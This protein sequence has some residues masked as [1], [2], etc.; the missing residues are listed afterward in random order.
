M[1][2]TT[3][4]GLLL[5]IDKMKYDLEHMGSY[6]GKLKIDRAKMRHALQY[7]TGNLDY[8]RVHCGVIAIDYVKSIKGQIKR[9]Q[10]FLTHAD[11]D[12]KKFEFLIEKQ[13]EELRQKEIELKDLQ[14]AL[15]SRVI[16]FRRRAK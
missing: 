13:T 10:A 5:L 14:C 12:I 3:I 16:I 15:G 4:E 9:L 7:N 6:I 2:S 11:N 8:L 1:G